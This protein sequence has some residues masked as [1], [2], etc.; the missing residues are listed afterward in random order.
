MIDENSDIV[1]AS[2]FQ[3]LLPANCARSAW[4]LGKCMKVQSAIPAPAERT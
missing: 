1:A 4:V 3:P 2:S